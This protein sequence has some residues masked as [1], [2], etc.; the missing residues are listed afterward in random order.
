MLLTDALQATERLTHLDAARSGLGEAQKLEGL[1]L[2]LQ[3]RAQRLQE[4]VERG[5]MLRSAGVA[6]STPP[7]GVAAR[8]TTAKVAAQFQSTRTA[9]V[10]TQG[11]RWVNLVAKLDALVSGLDALQ[12]QDWKT[13]FATQLFGGLSP[14]QRRTT[15]NHHHPSNKKAIERYTQLYAVFNRCRNALPA[16]AMVLHEVLAASKELGEIKFEESSDMPAAVLRFLDATGSNAGANL[17][18]VTVE[19]IDWLRTSGLLNSYVVRAK[20]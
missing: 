12:R 18:L 6:T 20:S 15:L 8:D 19:V 4:L 9:G 2:E 14:E 16:T 13:H 10:L 7:E 5:D 1:R 11:S 17:D 3:K